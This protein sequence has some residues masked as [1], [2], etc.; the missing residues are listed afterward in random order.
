MKYI[1][2]LSNGKICL[3]LTVLEKNTMPE[4][5]SRMDEA[6]WLTPAIAEILEQGQANT[7]DNSIR[8]VILTLQEDLNQLET[9]ARVVNVRNFTSY[10]L[11]VCKP[12]AIGRLGNR[13]TVRPEEIEASVAQINAQRPEWILGYSSVVANEDADHVGIYLRTKTHTSLNL[14]R[15]LV[16]NVFR[17]YA[18]TTVAPIG[19]D[20]EQQMYL[21]DLKDD[22]HFVLI[23]ENLRHQHIARGILLTLLLLNTP[24]ELRIAVAGEHIDPYKMFIG[25]PHA[26]GRLLTKPSSLVKLLDGLHKEI[27]RRRQ[28][29]Q[30]NGFE[31]LDEYNEKLKENSF[32]ILP[33]VLVMVDAVQA[34]AWQKDS[35]WRDALK[36]I[37][38]DGADVGI[39]AFVCVPYQDDNDTRT[40][41]EA[42]KRPIVMKSA[43]AELIQPIEDFHPSLEQFV[44]AFSV[45]DKYNA[46]PI[47]IYTVGNTEIRQAVEYWRNHA[48]QRNQEKSL[49]ISGKTGV[50]DILTSHHDEQEAV[51]PP[52][53]DI[54]PATMIQKATQALAEAN[55]DDSAV[56][57]VQD[58]VPSEKYAKE[59]IGS[60]SS[61]VAVVQQQ[62]RALAAYMGWLSVGALRD[63]LQLTEQDAEVVMV[64][65]QDEGIIEQSEIVS[66][67]IRGK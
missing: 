11:F 51:N 61:D 44:T 18:S 30:N 10:T 65:L 60:V 38:D 21:R 43:Q 4:L 52:V 33:R 53:P 5:F 46:H 41:I 63:I 20:I 25:S 40:L 66:R 16:R 49:D 56:Q 12:E 24:S 14:R 28:L 62:A 13:R 47:E 34:E 35:G 6:S 58:T 37:L 32:N 22:K 9:P 26:L 8:D 27:R 7:T 39:H 42:T 3:S 31:I 64:A 59:P 45:E 17:K 29:M 23:S 54:P 36:V 67:F 48:Q 55:D 50:T 15:I 19:I 57:D 2:A 1:K